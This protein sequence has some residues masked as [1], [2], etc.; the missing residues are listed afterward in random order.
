[1]ACSRCR[2]LSKAGLE[3]AG[4]ASSQPAREGRQSLKKR[5]E[6]KGVNDVLQTAAP[7]LIT[8]MAATGTHATTA[9]AT[10]AV[11]QRRTAGSLIIPRAQVLAAIVTAMMAGLYGPAV[12]TSATDLTDGDRT[13]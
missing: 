13:P 1:M 12:I 9:A 10:A 11:R 2:A 3:V 5:P 4:L 7:V 6:N 8:A